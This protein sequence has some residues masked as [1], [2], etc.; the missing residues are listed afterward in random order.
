[1]CCVDSLQEDKQGQIEKA[2]VADLSSCV[3]N[4][5][6]FYRLLNFA[7]HDVIRAAVEASFAIVK[8]MM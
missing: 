8:N 1:M 3:Y 4:A 2:R 6:F 5:R 7:G